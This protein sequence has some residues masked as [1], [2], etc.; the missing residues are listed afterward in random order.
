MKN[1]NILN[2]WLNRYPGRAL[3]DYEKVISVQPDS[4]SQGRRQPAPYPLPRAP[5]AYFRCRGKLEYTAKAPKKS[6]WMDSLHPSSPI[7]PKTAGGRK[8][9][10][11]AGGGPSWPPPKI[12]ACG[13][14]IFKKSGSMVL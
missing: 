7:N 9:L 3:W 5:G 1:N 12:S 10:E 6:R 8:L 13:G 4:G 11:T 2:K 14:P